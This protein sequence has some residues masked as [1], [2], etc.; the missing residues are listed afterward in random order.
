[1]HRFDTPSPIEVRIDVVG[2]AR[3][4]ASDRDD[5]IVHVQPRDPSKSKDRRAA[6]Q[7]TVEYAEGRLRVATAKSWR[8]FTP[9][10]G[11][12]LVSVTVEVPTASA[13]DATTGFGDLQLEGELGD[14]RLKTG[15]GA[16][17]V[18]RAAALRATTGFGDV[19]VDAVDGAAEATTGSGE[20]RLD[21]VGGATTVN[22]SNGATALGDCVG[23]VR[24]KSANGD[25]RIERARTSVTATTAC[26]DLRVLE[27]GGGDV[28]LETA[29]GLVEV[30]VRQG[31]AAWLD[32]STRFGTVRNALGDVAPPAPGEPT[33][34]V[35]A[36]TSAGDVLVGRAAAHSG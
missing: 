22:N 20:V 21:H 25:V 15:M 16:V 3:I 11:S 2:D 8:R 27:V 24:V 35:R 18:D 32:L 30:G 1:M 10:S 6:E 29:V 14:C 34:Q 19:T 7:T 31:V 23:P 13:V 28:S 12:E 5:T 36:R 4:T 33:V 9:T 26:G 17:R